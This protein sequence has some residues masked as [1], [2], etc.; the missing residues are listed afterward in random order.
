MWHGF[1]RHGVWELSIVLQ[2]LLLQ[3]HLISLFLAKVQEVALLAALHDVFAEDSV[4]KYSLL[5]EVEFASLERTHI[6]CLCLARLN[7]RVDRCVDRGV[8]LM[9]DD[10]HELHDLRLA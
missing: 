6:L 2:L 3:K 4:L 1:P 10:V 7:I 8:V 9:V 5:Q